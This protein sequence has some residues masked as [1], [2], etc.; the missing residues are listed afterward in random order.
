[1]CSIHDH[2]WKNLLHSSLPTCF[3]DTFLNCFHRNIQLFT[4]TDDGTVEVVGKIRTRK[5]AYKQLTS[6]ID[7]ALAKYPAGIQL[8]VAHGDASEEAESFMDM[9]KE[10]YPN[11]GEI[12]AGFLTPVLGVH[13]GPGALGMGYVARPENFIDEVTN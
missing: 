8:I 1:M 6:Y 2:T 10:Q 11:I 7:E 3:L 4:E 13:G 9:I 12:R 5:R